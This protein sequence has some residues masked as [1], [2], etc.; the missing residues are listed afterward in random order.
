MPGAPP[1]VSQA[2]KDSW[3]TNTNTAY[4]HGSSPPLMSPQ[5]DPNYPAQ[6]AHV[7]HVIPS[8]YAEQAQAKPPP[9]VSPPMELSAEQNVHELQSDQ[10]VEREGVKTRASGEDGRD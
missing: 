8:Y 3:H 2:E 1:Y 7:G 9:S 5:F 6:Y 4:S 10:P